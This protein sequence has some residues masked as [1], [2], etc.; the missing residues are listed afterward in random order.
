MFALLKLIG[1]TELAAPDTDRYL[2]TAAALAT[3]L[4][5]LEAVRRSL[6][7]RLEASP[8]RDE[9]GMANDL[10]IAYRSMWQ[11]WCADRSQA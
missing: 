2:S 9:V 10:D 6:R 11:A 4:D 8:L 3:N 5:Q 1:L 7:A